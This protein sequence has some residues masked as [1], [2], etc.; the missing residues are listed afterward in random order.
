[1]ERTSTSRTKLP[2]HAQLSSWEGGAHV[3]TSCSYSVILAVLPFISHLPR[4]PPKKKT[5][6]TPLNLVRLAEDALDPTVI[7]LREP[8]LRRNLNR[9]H[10]SSALTQFS[11]FILTCISKLSRISPWWQCL[12]GH[13]LGLPQTHSFL[14]CYGVVLWQGVLCRKPGR[15]QNFTSQPAHPATHHCAL[16]AKSLISSSTVILFF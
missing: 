12:F 11:A 9:C 3:R 14:Q 16:F 2:L 13:I 10:L 1:M 6:I 4:H 15:L 5:A 7:A 8:A